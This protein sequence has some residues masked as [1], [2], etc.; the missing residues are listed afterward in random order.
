MLKAAETATPSLQ[1]AL[2][3]AKKQD[4]AVFMMYTAPWCPECNYMKE[5]V[6]EQKE[7]KHYL[8]QHFVMIDFNVDKDELPKG[9]AHIG[10]PTY[11]VIC[12]DGRSQ[13]TID[14]GSKAAAFLKKLKALPLCD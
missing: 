9:F 6:F 3:T 2:N 11:F 10:I 7:V 5:V 8:D 4:K 12:S 13:I 14:G 1:Q